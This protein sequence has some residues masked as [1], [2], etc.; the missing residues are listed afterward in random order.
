M[1]TVKISRKP[2]HTQLT[3]TL[4]REP[5]QSWP[6]HETARDA[7]DRRCGSCELRNPRLVVVGGPIWPIPAIRVWTDAALGDI[8]SVP[9]G[10]SSSPWMDGVDLDR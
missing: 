4:R 7:L 9:N 5:M 6:W 3:C 2:A 10:R 1:K 8:T